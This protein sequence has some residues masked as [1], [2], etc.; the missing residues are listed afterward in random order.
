MRNLVIGV[1]AAG[2]CVAMLPKMASARPPYQ[3][4]FY[5]AY[6]VK[7]ES[8]LAMAKCQLCHMGDDKTVRNVYGMALGKALGKPK[9]TPE[10]VTAAAKKIE[11]ELSADKKTKFIDLIK[12]DKLPG[13][14]A[15]AK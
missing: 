8:K 10:E 14:P 13:L 11:N 4:A 5:T 6:N 7:P 2:A 1:L 9:A 12:A 3:A 15:E